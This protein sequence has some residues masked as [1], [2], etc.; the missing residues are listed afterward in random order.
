MILWCD[1]AYDPAENMRRDLRLLAAA[2]AGAPPVLR[3]FRFAPHGI[4]LGHAQDPAR[5]LDLERLAADG[6][7]WASRPTGGRA[8]FHAEEWTYSLASPIADPDWGGSLATAYERASRLLLRSLVRPACRRTSR[9]AVPAR[10]AK[11]P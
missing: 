1:G 9:R 4:T 2:E 10:R 6:V 8:I 5:E 11:P 7:P 3:L